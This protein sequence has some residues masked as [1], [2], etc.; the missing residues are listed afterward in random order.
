M[1]IFKTLGSYIYRWLKLK[2]LI[3]IYVLFIS[4][5]YCD[6]WIFLPQSTQNNTFE[7]KE[8][9]KW[10]NA[11]STY[12]VDNIQVDSAKDMTNLYSLP[13]WCDIQN[14]TL[15]G[16]QIHYTTL[17]FSDYTSKMMITWWGKMTTPLSWHEE[18][19][20][21]L[22]V[23]TITN[24]QRIWIRVPNNMVVCST[25]EPVTISYVGNTN[26]I[27]LASEPKYNTWGNPKE[28]TIV[29]WFKKVY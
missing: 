7:I 22:C 28:R 26:N 14:Y 11:T 16:G 24:D 15:Q 25:T 29:I 19:G 5:A 10:D 4:I 9:K 1:I 21:G 12:L 27:W 17:T 23:F 6:Q 18:I 3:T 8:T 2:N 20:T 13:L